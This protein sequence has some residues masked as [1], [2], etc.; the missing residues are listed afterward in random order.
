MKRINFNIKDR[1]LLYGVLSIVLVCIFS[2][3]IAYAALSAVLTINGNAEVVS[4]TWDVYLANVHVKDGSV[5]GGLPSIVNSTTASFS[6]TLSKPGDY[7]EFFIDVVNNGSIDAMIE[8]IM[9]TPTLSTAQEK[10]INYI[11]EYEN[12]ESLNEKQLIL[13]KSYVRLKIRI[14]YRRDLTEVDLP[15]SSE[16]ISLGFTINYIQ[17][18]GTG[19]S[20]LN[21]GIDNNIMEFTIINNGISSV[22]E[23]LEN[24]SWDECMSSGY[25]KNTIFACGDMYY[26]NQVVYSSDLIIPNGVYTYIDA[27]SCGGGS[28]D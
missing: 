10:Y 20:V 2:L 12:G 6:T 21:N 9:K 16:T 19:S 8:S 7:Y 27:G 24:M 22:Y 4:S 25:C 18:D 11:I 1:K 15:S 26:N 5:D 28:N 17:S 13:K 3:S 14:E 23:A